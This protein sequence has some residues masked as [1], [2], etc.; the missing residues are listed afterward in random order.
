VHFRLS[1]TLTDVQPRWIELEADTVVVMGLRLGAAGRWQITYG[2]MAL[3][4]SSPQPQLG[5][6]WQ[7]AGWHQPVPGLLPPDTLSN[8]ALQSQARQWVGS[9]RADTLV[10]LTAKPNLAGRA[11]AQQQQMAESLMG[12][13][14]GREGCELAAALS[15]GYRL[16]LDADDSM[17]FATAGVIHLLAISGLHVGL[18]V[19]L[20]LGLWT[21]GQ[22]AIVALLTRLRLRQA[23]NLP[24]AWLSIGLV[25]LSHPGWG[26]LWVMVGLVGYVLLTGAGPSAI[27]AGWFAALGLGA[28][29]LWRRIPLWGLWGML[30]GGWLLWDPAVIFAPGFVLSFG[31]VA[32]I[33]L[34]YVPVARRWRPRWRAFRWLRDLLLI[35]AAAQLGALPFSLFFFGQFPTYFLVANVLAIPLALGLLY[36]GLIWS[37]LNAVGWAAG[38]GG[39]V[40]L[41]GWLGWGLHAWVRWINRWP[42]A[43]L[44]VSAL[45][46]Q[47]LWQTGLLVVGLG[48]VWR[49][50]WATLGRKSTALD[51]PL[52]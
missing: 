6:R 18:V 19:V 35:S 5:Q 38:A 45:D 3:D 47:L 36:L 25:R 34:W 33:M 41:M 7:V 17:G 16:G 10:C 26:W 20:L 32:G 49:W 43:V 11:S 12:G 8:Q 50:A 9:M 27:R 52:A 30:L 29:V 2:T 24:P 14:G 13:C 42:G 46:L 28:R 31:A 39:L 15:L 23:G 40:P 21:V 1:G 51:F 4:A 37:G 48:L 44:E 22:W